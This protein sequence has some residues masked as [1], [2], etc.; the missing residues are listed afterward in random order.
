MASFF[1]RHR[2]DADVQSKKNDCSHIPRG[3]LPK[4]PGDDGRVP[5]FDLLAVI[6]SLKRSAH[7]TILM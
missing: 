3:V 2:K 4:N 1:F 7:L 6:N 5:F